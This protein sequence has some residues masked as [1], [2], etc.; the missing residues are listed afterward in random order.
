MSCAY[1]YDAALALHDMGAGHPECPQRIQVIHSALQQQSYFN[2][3]LKPRFQ[4]AQPEAILRVHSEQ[5]LEHLHRVS[6]NLGMAILDAD[7][8]MNVNSLSNALLAAGAGIAAVEGLVA[9]Q[10][11]RAFCNVR[12]PGHHAVPDHAMGFCFFNNVAIAALHAQTLGLER[13]A[14]LDWDVH[15]GNGTE[16]MLAGQKNLLMLGSF[17][18]PFYPGSG[19]PPLADNIV[20]VPL[21]A[22]SNGAAVRSAATNV[23][24][25]RL[26]QFKPDLIIVSAGF[27]AHQDDSMSSLQWSDDDY[28]WLTEQ[29]VA[30]A[31]RYCQGRV[32]SMLE[33][34]YDLA[35]LARCAV[36]H[37]QQL[38]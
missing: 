28:R 26:E 10:F 12:P 34:G 31:Q 36:L 15:H 25:P 7:T 24:W 35:A 4:P 14:I 32:V 20:N 29:V 6:P 38:V 17:Q 16:V 23:W 3:L 19:A 2:S 5:Y 13:I 18:H 27:D 21:P 22:G 33:G 9:K 11:T 30:M 8:S 37:V 1:F